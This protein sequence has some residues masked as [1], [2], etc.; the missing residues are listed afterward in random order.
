[1]TT[2]L[3][4]NAFHGDSA[5]CVV[6][7]GVLVNAAE[8]ER[9][10]RVKHWAGFP[11]QAIAWCLADAG[12]TLAEVDHVAVNQDS[13]ANLGRKVAYTLLKRPDLSM[14]LDRIRNKR[15]REGI[16]AHLARAF[17]GQAFA[18]R[19]HAVEHHVAHLSS[20]FHVSPFDE[21]VVVS[22]DGFG[23]FASA[24]W[25]L[26]RG[27]Q[28]TV[29]DRVYFP[30]S[31]GMF[32]QALTQYLGFPNY[33]DEYKVMGLAPYGEPGHIE[34]MRK[35]VRLHDDGGFSLNL[36]YFRHAREKV[37]YEWEQGSPSVG[38]LFTPALEALLGPARKASDPLEQKH[39]DIARSVQAM[40]EEAFFHLLNA[41]HRRY[42]VSAVCV[43]GGCGMNSVANGKITVRT[44]FTQVYVQSAAGDAGGAIGAA[45]A[46]WHELGGARAAPMLHAYL[47]PGCD[48]DEIAALLQ[49]RA[50]EI[51]AAGCVRTT[52]ADEGALCA[53]TARAVADGKVVGWFQGRM[54]WGPRALGNRSILGDPRRA[55]MKDILNL[56]IKRRES[57]RPFAPSVLREAVPQW[58]ELDGDV[59]FMMQVYP[60]RAE[61]R[62]QIPAVT[63]VDGS[64][65]LQT[66]EASANPRYHGLI[67]AF[68]DLTGVPMVLNTSFN[69]NEPVVCRPAEALDCFLRTRMDVLVLGDEFIERIAPT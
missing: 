8:E 36:D 67:A 5:A 22:V 7:D 14:V 48:A 63:H 29:D 61:R 64:G 46:V 4:I 42:P 19:L 18:G 55:D 25:G 58:F 1:M 33:G 60:I 34:A 12:L 38:T 68:R 65:R 39:K 49:D 28:I 27:T 37:E 57:F 66:V 17:P 54:E 15:E 45:F 51:E 2:I 43:A 16:D 23:D 21:A 32:Y 56:K 40:Y 26:G 3:G 53:R 10:R 24:A 9:F 59:P 35:I 30:H 11:S 6:R 44:P 31:L 69:E 13:S 50:Q 62:A 41:L 20:A 47:G 52:F